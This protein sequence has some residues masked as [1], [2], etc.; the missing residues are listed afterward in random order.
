[1]RA[2]IVEDEPLLNEE[3]EEQLLEEQFT[4]DTALDF[5]TAEDFITGEL[6]DLVLLDLSLPGGDGLD[7]LKMLKLHREN[8][9]TAVIILTARGDIDDRVQ[10]LELGSD[11]YLSKPFAMPELRARIHAVLRRKFKINDNVITIRRLSVHLD[12]LHVSFEGRPLEVTD[13][14][15]KMLRYL[16]L[17]KNKTITRIALAEHIWGNKIDDRFSLDFINSHMKNIRKKLGE[18]GVPDMIETVYGV[19]YKLN[20]YEAEQ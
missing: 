19:G 7:L 13:T 10:G 6:Y 14:E 2:L 4:V 3:L 17:N 15:Y 5:S 8:E 20:G 12:H 11:D 9:D 16:F 1:M 18:S